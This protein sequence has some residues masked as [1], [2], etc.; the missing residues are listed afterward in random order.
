[1]KKIIRK[2]QD[3]DMK[4]VH[5]KRTFRGTFAMASILLV[6]IIIAFLSVVYS[7]QI[8]KQFFQVQNSSHI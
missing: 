1:M 3:N 8:Q 4:I 2:Q 6:I 5:D 7:K